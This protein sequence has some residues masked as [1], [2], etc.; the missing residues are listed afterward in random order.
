MIKSLSRQ[1]AKERGDKVYTPERP[2]GKGHTKRYT[3]NGTCV[4]CMA[5]R[6]GVRII[7]PAT[8]HRYHVNSYRL[9]APRWVSIMATNA[10]NRAKRAGAP[11]DREAV[12]ECLQNAPDVCPALG[13]PLTAG[14]GGEKKGQADTA[15]S[16]DRLNPTLGYVRGNL[17]VVSSLANR[18]MTDATPEKLRRVADWLEEQLRK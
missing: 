9:R 13:L 16:L 18:I 7:H 14:N 12:C 11:F 8:Q 15:A 5:K 4:E 17:A 2:C 6:N 1:A 3:S 10:K